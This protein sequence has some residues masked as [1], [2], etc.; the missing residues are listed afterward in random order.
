MKAELTAGGVLALAGVAGVAALAWTLYAKRG[1][2]AGAAGAAVQAVNP[3]DAQN[4]VNRAV[5][6]AGAGLSGD[7]SW[8]LGGWLADRFSPSVAAANTMLQSPPSKN[9]RPA[10]DSAIADRWDYYAKGGRNSANGSGGP[11]PFETFLQLT[12]GT[13][14]PLEYAAP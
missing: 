5:T 2:I 11:D 10:V 4:L 14:F 13:G 6:A 1:A 3:A 9:A 12:N 7:A 8:T